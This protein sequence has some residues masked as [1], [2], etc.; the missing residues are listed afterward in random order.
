M[1]RDSD[2]QASVTLLPDRGGNSQALS[3]SSFCDSSRSKDFPNHSTLAYTM[4]LPMYSSR[5][6]WYMIQHI[7]RQY[8]GS[9][10]GVFGHM[11][12]VNCSVRKHTLIS[13]IQ[14][15]GRCG[16][17][18]LQRQRHEFRRRQIQNLCPASVLHSLRS[19]CSVD[20]PGRNAS[21]IV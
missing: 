21:F 16:N 11:H 12:I 2:R 9:D 4:I 5:A 18:D 7:E 3:T 6:D 8:D 1:G 10:V 14:L 19:S 20:P 15:S 17:N 13:L